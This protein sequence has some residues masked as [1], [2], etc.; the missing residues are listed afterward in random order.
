MAEPGC[1]IETKARRVA[2]TEEN[3]KICACPL[4][5][6]YD[7][8]MKG[9][10]ELLYCARASSD[11]EVVRKGCVCGQCTVAVRARLSLNYYCANGPADF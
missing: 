3:A 7:E 9:R 6:T 10:G 5:P 8:C 4:C 11:C 2:D 1:Y